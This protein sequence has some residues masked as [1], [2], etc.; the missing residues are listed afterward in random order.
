M[1]VTD[2]R[3][4]A[5]TYFNAAWD[6][7]DLESRTPE[8]EHELL[9]LVF[10][11]RK[12]WHEA[13]GS[14]DNLITS[15]WQVAHA[16]SL[17]RLPD[18]ALRFAKAAAGQAETADVPLWLKASTH[19]GLARAHAAAGDREA[20]SR[21]ARLTRELLDAVADDEERELIAGQLASIPQP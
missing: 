8:Q 9:T 20:H 7:I 15:D 12:H 11:S 19:E 1:A 16:A 14:P 4:L 17:V 3:L 5:A 21:E 2:H 6:L 13:G 18:L 10:A